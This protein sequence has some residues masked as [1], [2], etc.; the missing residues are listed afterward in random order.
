MKR[1]SFLRS[2]LEMAGLVALPAPPAHARPRPVLLQTSPV[3]GFQYHDGE[4]VWPLLR[5][6]DPL[7][8]I[9]EPGNPH[10]PKAVRVE[11][12]GHKLGYV[13]RTENV[14]VVQMLDRGDRLEARIAHLIES[15]SPWQRVKTEIWLVP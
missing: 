1:R 14:A 9:R 6:G 5:A 2:L 11:W 13:P 3:A 12:E 8:L 15:P 4:A 10:D 7:A